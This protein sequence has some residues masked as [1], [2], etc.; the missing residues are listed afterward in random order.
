MKTKT[1]LIAAAALV[2]GVVSSE[3]QVYSANIVGYANVVVPKT[4]FTL[5][6]NPLNDGTNT[7]DDVMAALPT[8]STLQLWNGTG[9]TIYT[10]SSSGFTTNS[11]AVNPA[12]PVGSGFFVSSAS[13]FT[14]TFVGTVVPG[15]GG[16]ISTNVLPKTSLVL[17][18]SILPVSG[19]FDDVGTNT[20]N[21]AAT[22]PTKSTVQLWNGA[23]FTLYTKSSTGFTTNSV[24]VNPAYSIG[25]GFFISSASATNWIQIEQ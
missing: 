5:L 10:K 19:F 25:Q 15:P 8:K 14:N 18:G 4:T 11:V 16:N 22:L 2:A 6:S 1:L 21:L 17:L 24:A 13:L 23:S 3:A 12:I 9:F 7:A 20:F